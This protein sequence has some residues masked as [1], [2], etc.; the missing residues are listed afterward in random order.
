MGNKTRVKAFVAL[1][2]VAAVA[3]VVVS[4]AFYWPPT[5]EAGWKS[6]AGLAAL[7]A[8]VV[9]AEFAGIRFSAGR[10]ILSAG[11]IPIVATVPLFGP[12]VA[13]GAT[14]MSEAVARLTLK[15]PP[16]KLIFNT[17]QLTVAIGF[18]AIVYVLLDGPI[19]ATT[20]NL[21][22]TLFP[23]AGLILV[24]F[25]VN[26]GLVSAVIALD[27][28]KS[29]FNAW[30]EIGAVAFAND[31]ASSSLALFVVYAFAELGIGGLLVVV[32]PLLFVHHSYGLYLRLQRQNKE[33]L[34]LLVKTIEAKD[35]YTSGHSQRVA[36]LSRDIAGAVGLSDRAIEEIE[37]AALL[38]D[39]GKIDF[40]YS[41]FIESPAKL[42]AEERDII[43]SH[44]QRGAELLQSISSM[45]KTVLDGVRHHHEHFDGTGYPSGL[46]GAEI[47][48][49]ARVIMVADTVDAML[50]H[51][52]YR[53]ALSVA[54]VTAELE[55]FAGRQFDPRIVAP[56]LDSNLVAEAAERAKPEYPA[57]ELRRKETASHVFASQ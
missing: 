53:S 50:S 17:A 11:L 14:A 40:A 55:K 3:L 16:I 43:R 26:T 21:G 47:P 39:I 27:T 28:G 34:Q 46:K 56:V 35:P 25:A 33:I 42:S 6:W 31:L 30:K 41:E 8:V 29:V 15:E 18:G 23:F 57:P 20:F 4:F 2:A 9:A 54:D 51:R 37:T 10:V 49:A 19:S 5:V 44:P 32:L 12:A 22:D 13:V 1:V 45:S 7:I 36:R 38:H 48:M 52:P 24:Y